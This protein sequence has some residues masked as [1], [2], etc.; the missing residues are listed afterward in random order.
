M[1]KNL[2]ASAR[3][4][5]KHGFDPWVGKLPWKKK[6]QPTPIFVH[7]ESHG[8]RGLPFLVFHRN[9]PESP[10]NIFPWPPTMVGMSK[11]ELCLWLFLHLQLSVFDF[12]LRH[13]TQE[14]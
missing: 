11:T 14:Q 2:T 12:K 7:G 4:C 8:Q 6:W 1:V 5:R 10:I 9:V 3:Q 13:K